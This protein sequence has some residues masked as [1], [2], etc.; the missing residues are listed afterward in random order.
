M[1]TLIHRDQGLCESLL[2]HFRNSILTV[3]YPRV[4]DRESGGY[5]SD[6]GFDWRI[7]AAQP[8][9]IVT[10]AH[11]VW[12]TARAAAFFGNDEELAGYARHGADFI[13]DVMWDRTYGG[14][15]QIR[16][17]DG[18]RTGTGGWNDE[19][20]LHGNASAI[21]ALAALYKHTGDAADL[22]LA[23]DGF[24]WIEDHAYDAARDGYVQFLTR[25]G[26]PFG[27]DGPHRSAAP[28][29]DVAGCR[30][31]DSTMHLLGAYTELYAAWQDSTLRERLLGLLRL[32]RDRMV[33]EKGYLRLFFSPALEHI[34]FHDAP[35]E[36]RLDNYPVDHVS[37]GHDYEAAFLMLE[38]SY[39]LGIENDARTLSIAKRML[40][41]AIMNGWDQENGGFVEGGLYLDG[42][43]LCTILRPAKRWWAQAEALNILL[44]FSSIF[45]HDN[46]YHD[47]FMRQWEYIDG[48]LIDHRHGDWFEG[49][50][51]REPHAATAPKGTIW[52]STYHTGK[53]LMNCIALLS[54]DA[55]ASPGILA[56]RAT[57]ERMINHWKRT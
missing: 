57:M 24:Q 39:A 33:T 37:F 27:K 11:H 16:D 2:N 30:D 54:D 22:A 52:K 56:H 31:A 6:L 25:E 10:Q 29:A 5:F 42:P 46:T 21:L 12:T 51:D 19:K 43:D 49:G 55:V 40:E 26:I 44:I 28:D 7:A 13:R 38:A 3:W 4:I 41:H 15:Y 53:A 45:P 14:F 36:D 9:M 48:Y 32:V 1:A 8:K 47:L 18:K 34:S 23:Q 50:L 35:R 20:R 17:R